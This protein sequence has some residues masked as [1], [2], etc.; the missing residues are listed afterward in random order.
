[1]SSLFLSNIS[2][3]CDEAELLHWVETRGFAV[4]SV[5]IVRDMVAGV[6]PGF[7]YVALRNQDLNA[8]AIKELNG[9]NLKGRSVEVKKDWRKATKRGH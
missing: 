6:S 1:M 5:R 4:D 3:D 7:G 2:H 8:Q 9:Q